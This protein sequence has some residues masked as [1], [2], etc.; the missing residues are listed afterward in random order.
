[1]NNPVI[2]ISD[3]LVSGS[4]TVEIVY[5]SNLNNIQL[6]R[7]AIT[8]GVLPSNFL[9]YETGYQSYGIQSATVIPYTRT[10]IVVAP[11]ITAED[12][13]AVLSKDARR[14]YWG[15]IGTENTEYKWF[16]DFKA[17]C[18]DTFIS[19]YAPKANDTY[20]LTRKGFY[21]FVVNEGGKDYVYTVECTVDSAPAVDMSAENA[22][23]TLSGNARKVY[24]GYIGEENTAYAGFTPFKEICGDTF[25][26]DFSPKDSKAYRMEKE[27]YYRF[28]VNY[29]D[30]NGK[31][32]DKVFTFKCE[33][34]GYGIPDVT[35]ADGKIT[36]NSNEA[37]VNKMYIGYFGEETEV[38]DWEGFVANAKA[39]ACVLT[40][41]DNYETELKNEGC[42]VILVN[43]T[44][45]NGKN[46]DKYFTFNN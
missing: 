30:Q 29:L 35:F 8:E 2:D 15:Y 11:E 19:E 12:N 4:N 26:A 37:K 23:A 6:S 18:G 17:E 40:P 46:K 44:D 38:S 25:T 27:G 9:G 42:Y 3:L 7:G 43:Y 20:E 10:E 34:A 22:V 32:H 28:V 5:S 31:S 39:R 13:K 24:F 45:E 21:R 33:N 41:T 36:L 14:V 1:M 16:N